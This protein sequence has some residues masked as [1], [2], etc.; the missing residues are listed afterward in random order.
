LFEKMRNFAGVSTCASIRGCMSRQYESTRGRIWA[1]TGA[2]G[3]TNRETN[4]GTKTN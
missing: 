1:K 2:Y 3:E 4:N